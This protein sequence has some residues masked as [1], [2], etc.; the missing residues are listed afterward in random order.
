[1]SAAYNTSTFNLGERCG[2]GAGLS[3][4]QVKVVHADTGELVAKFCRRCATDL[5]G[6]RKTEDDRQMETEGRCFP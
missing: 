3:G 5:V 4:F 1:M 6:L 2:C